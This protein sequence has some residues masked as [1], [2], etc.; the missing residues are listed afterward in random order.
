MSLVRHYTDWATSALYLFNSPDK[1]PLVIFQV[2]AVVRMKM[3]RL[4]GHC[5]VSI[6]KAHQ[7]PF[8][9]PTR[10]AAVYRWL[11]C[12]A[13]PHRK[14]PP[15]PAYGPTNFLGS[16]CSTNGFPE[17]GLIALMMELVSTSE[18]SANCHESARRN[19]LKTA[20]INVWKL[21][22]LQFDC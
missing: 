5:A 18:T 15:P 20:I 4:L 17:R 11:P 19:I 14:L 6:H 10:H 2:L 9:P 1:C 21:V 13:C 8:I 22:Y 16:A 3:T 12:T 7:T